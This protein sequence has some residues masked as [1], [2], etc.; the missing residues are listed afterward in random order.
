MG[1]NMSTAHI[2]IGTSSDGKACGTGDYEVGSCA[3]LAATPDSGCR[4][5]QWDDGISLNPRTVVVTGNET[6]KA[7][8]AGDAPAANVI[9]YNAATAATGDWVTNNTDTSLNTYDSVTGDGVLY[10]NA[11]VTT[12]GGGQT[13]TY[14]PF[15]N[16]TDL[17]SVDLA[18]SGLTSIS[19]SAFAA[20]SGLTSITIP[21]SVTSIGYHTFEACTSLTSINIPSGVTSIGGYAF[22]GSGLTSVTLPNNLTSMGRDAFSYCTGLTSITIPNSVTRIYDCAFEECTGLTSVTIGSGVTII[23]GRAFYN[24]T[25]LTSVTCL[26]TTPP[27]LYDLN[28]TAS[29]DTLYVPAASLSAYQSDT[30]WSAAFTTITAIV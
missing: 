13:T 8:F 3:T 22:C 2:S 15:Y 30:D 18:D 21:S 26:A 6:Y 9:R 14:S 7:Q 19:D 24:C 12:I 25:G 10:L 11:G 4:F 5:V 27:T 20:C 23:D 29:N 17:L 1:L 28:F 16:K